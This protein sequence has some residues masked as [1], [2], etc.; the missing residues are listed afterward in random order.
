MVEVVIALLILLVGL[1]AVSRLFL[2]ALL[3]EQKAANRQAATA[4]VQQI[5]EEMRQGG[6]S[7]LSAYAGNKVLWRKTVYKGG[8]QEVL[9]VQYML[10]PAGAN[11][12]GGQNEK[13]ERIGTF[14]V[15]VSDFRPKV[16]K[17][18]VKTTAGFTKTT[19]A[20]FV[21]DVLFAEE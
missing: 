17:A 13:F 1:L 7:G 10:L 2:A 8:T 16:K 11:P 15:T 20:G 19:Q 9:K 12:G 18:E 3:A 14:S 21:T 6:V 5:V 4:A